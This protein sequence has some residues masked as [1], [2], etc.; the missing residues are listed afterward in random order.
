MGASHFNRVV[1]D[2]NDLVTAPR[3]TT[4]G[5]IIQATE[6][7]TR[8]GLVV[9]EALEIERKLNRAATA[10][11]I[12]RDP[13]L[14]SVVLSCAGLST[15]AQGHLNK[16]QLKDIA[17]AAIDEI[18]S[19]KGE[20]GRQILFR[21]LLTAGDSLGGAM[22][23]WTG[24]S[25]QA[26]VTQL[27]KDR[28]TKAGVRPVVESSDTGKTQSIQWEKRLIAFDRTPKF[29]G[30][31]IDVILL[32]SQSDETPTKILVNTAANFLAIGEIKGGIDPAGAD[33]HWKTASKALQRVREAFAGKT[34]PKLFF[35]GVAI[36]I[37]MA[38]EIFEEV[39]NGT[40]DFAA[41]LTSEKQA[42]ALAD[43]LISL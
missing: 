34:C 23:N 32:M 24:S 28:L 9:K 36:E 21:F 14:T 15:K 43:W 40:L 25:A 37:A 35:A 2:P 4:R 12:L 31:N 11:E 18:A 7:M 29:I 26:Q 3:E 1:K 30:K 42:S 27:L 38:K 33:E 6:K 20:L 39:K 22:R 41:N 5:F 13:S 10:E 17:R 8:A 19:T 16:R